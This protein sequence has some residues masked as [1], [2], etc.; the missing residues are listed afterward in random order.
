M[1]SRQRHWRG[2][3]RRCYISR[4]SLPLG[5]GTA[6]AAA[7][8]S[9]DCLLIQGVNIAADDAAAVTPTAA[10][11]DSMSTHY[12]AAVVATATAAVTAA[13][14]PDAVSIHSEAGY[15][16]TTSHLSRGSHF[17]RGGYTSEASATFRT[18]LA[19]EQLAVGI[20]GYCSS[21]HTPHFKPS[22]LEFNRIL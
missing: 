14:S 7:A 5:W 9:S 12:E 15:A 8:S 4:V 13:A 2:R 19:R 1:K 17:S 3:R 20:D 21:R 18:A 11:P 6:T 10:A 16:S 22:P